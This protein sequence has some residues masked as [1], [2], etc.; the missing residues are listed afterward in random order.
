[1]GSD[2]R[3][4]AI[5]FTDTGSNTDVSNNVITTSSFTLHNETSYDY[6]Y[7]VLHEFILVGKE[8]AN[9]SSAVMYQYFYLYDFISGHKIIEWQFALKYLSSTTYQLRMRSYWYNSSGATNIDD[10]SITVNIDDVKYVR[11]ALAISD[12]DISTAVNMFAYL[13]VYDTPFST[14]REQYSVSLALSKNLTRTTYTNGVRW[15]FDNKEMYSRTSTDDKCMIEI[16]PYYLYDYTDIFFTTYPFDNPD[17][18][19]FPRDDISLTEVTLTHASVYYDSKFSANRYAAIDY[20]YEL[21]QMQLSVDSLTDDVADLTQA[22]ADAKDDIKG[23]S[24]K[25]NTDLWNSITGAVSDIA[26]LA[27]GKSLTDVIS[28]VT[29]LDISNIIGTYSLDDLWTGLSNNSSAIIDLAS[30]KTLSDVISEVTG[31]DLSNIIG[32]TSLDDIWDFLSAL[33]ELNWDGDWFQN[34]VNSAV[35]YAFATTVGSSTLSIL[36]SVISSDSVYYLDQLGAFLVSIIA[37]NIKKSIGGI[38]YA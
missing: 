29:G 38:T 5:G 13:E 26:D 20:Q 31:L 37:N 35:S 11:M 17:I 32:L 14:N 23:T 16:G 2:E 8:I 3:V 15:K 22:L 12:Y 28:E 10:D 24:D 18:F 19:W 36:T 4:K 34:L 7:A 6:S 25:D 30:G 1:L 33:G 21:N 9:Y 27:T